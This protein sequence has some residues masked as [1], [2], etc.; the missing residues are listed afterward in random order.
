TI[1]QLVNAYNSATGGEHIV[2]PAGTVLTGEIVLPYKAF[3]DYVT[4]RSSGTMPDIRERISPNNAGLV[5]IRGSAVGSIPL[6]IK[7]RA[8]KIR[9]I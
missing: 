1:S 5:T 8:S 3:S 4:I 2:I 6:T 9:L 7:S